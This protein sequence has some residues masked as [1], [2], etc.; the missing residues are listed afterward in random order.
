MSNKIPESGRST[1]DQILDLLRD[2]LIERQKARRSQPQ[3]PQKE[4]AKPAP[5]TRPEPPPSEQQRPITAQRSH[6]P[7]VVTKPPPE[8]KPGEE[9]WEPPPRQSSINMGKTIGRLTILVVVLL[10][11]LNARLNLRQY[12]YGRALAPLLQSPAPIEN[13]EPTSR[14][15]ADRPR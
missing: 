5:P 12:R 3:Q 11:L 8:P 6:S 15:R 10:I 9:G 14:E 2:A 13:P 1:T 4:P 7:R